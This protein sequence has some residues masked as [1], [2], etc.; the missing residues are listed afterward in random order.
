MDPGS[1]CWGVSYT[2]QLPLTTV[3]DGIVTT[4]AD[5]HGETFDSTAYTKQR[6]EGKCGGA[7]FKMRGMVFSPAHLSIWPGPLSRGWGVVE[8][9]KN[10]R[11]R[12]IYLY[13]FDNHIAQVIETK[14]QNTFNEFLMLANTQYI[15]NVGSL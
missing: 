5:I 10:Y 2:F 3:F 15:E 1:R 9:K 8:G 14:V 11:R 7:S 12:K 13:E 4:A 6:S